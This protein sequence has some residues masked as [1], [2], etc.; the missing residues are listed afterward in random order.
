M[1]TDESWHGAGWLS[2]NCKQYST[3]HL[4][5]IVI[6]KL[7]FYSLILGSALSFF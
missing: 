7:Y 1:E 4:H 3:S 6:L 5:V 2:K